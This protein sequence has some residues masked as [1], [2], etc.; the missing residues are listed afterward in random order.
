MK[1]M[2]LPD[3]ETCSTC[4]HVERCKMIGVFISTLLPPPNE[5]TECD[6]S[7]SRYAK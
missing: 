3:G 6:W 5:R 7:P 1:D 4:R 2:D